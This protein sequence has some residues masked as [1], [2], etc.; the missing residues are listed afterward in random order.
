MLNPS[1]PKYSLILERVKEKARESGRK[2]DE[3]TL[4]AVTKY[5]NVESI[6]QVYQDGGRNFG[7]SRLQ[8]GLKKISC[9]PDNSKWHFIGTLQSN[10]IAKVLTHFDLIHSVDSFEL[11]KKISEMSEGRANCPAILLQV[12][13]SLEA[14][15]HGLTAE[16]WE[17][18]LDGM[19][20]FKGVRIEGLMTMAP[21][22]TDQ[23]V[24]R[25]C[26]RNLYRLREKWS[27]KMSQPQ[28]FKHLS[29]GMSNDY[30]IAIEEGATLLRIGTAIFS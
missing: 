25:K 27:S 4:I 1:Q 12:N 6:K 29:M 26:F 10:K 30:L 28:I 2:A 15:K 20:E 3:I 18:Y 8:E 5:Q 13:T 24:I 9:V 14:S 16:G 17:V 11:A 19:N 21:L 23:D 22:T 7:E